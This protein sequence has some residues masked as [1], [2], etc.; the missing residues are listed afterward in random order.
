[1]QLPEAGTLKVTTPLALMLAPVQVVLG[2]NVKLAPPGSDPVPYWSLLPTLKVAPTVPAGRVT[3]SLEAS[4]MGMGVA[5]E[6]AVLLV[7]LG[8]LVSEEALTVKVTP[9]SVVL[10]PPWLPG[11]V[12]VQVQA[13]VAPGAREATGT[14]GVQLTPET[15]PA[16]AVMLQVA[17]VAESGPLLVQEKLKV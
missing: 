1:M 9:V 12:K 13:I 4:T 5:P 15:V 16:E 14:A 7:L 10:P 8:S 17:F 3:A 2:S 11:A 6:V